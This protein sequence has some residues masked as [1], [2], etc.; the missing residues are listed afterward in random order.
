MV[1][2][3]NILSEKQACF[4]QLLL[5][6]VK[7]RIGFGVILLAI[8]FN[9]CSVN[10]YLD[11]E[12]Y[13]LQSNKLKF[14][15]KAKVK[16]KPSLQ[17]ELSLKYKQKPNS[18]FLFL[19]PREWVYYK[20][21]PK[22][23]SSRFNKWLLT[24]IAE[25]PTIY[26]GEKSQQTVQSIEET[27][28]KKGYYDAEVFYD[29]EIKGKKANVTYYVNPG[30]LYTV[31]KITYESD[32]KEIRSILNNEK[33]D[34]YFKNGSAL[35]DENYAKERDRIVKALQNNGYA[36]FLRD[37]VS[38]AEADTT[39]D[40]K[41]ADVFIKILPPYSDSIH[42][43]YSVG[44]ITIYPNFSPLIPKE[45]LKEQIIEEHKFIDTTFN[46]WVKPS[47][48]INAIAL[49]KGDLYSI[50]ND[51]KTNRR[52]S[53]LGV[54]KFI[55][56]RPEVAP[57]DSTVLNFRIELTPNKKLEIGLDF[58]LNYSN[59]NS[60]GRPG[61]LFG[62]TGSP[63]FRN[64]N[65]FKGA[66]ALVTNLTGGMEFNP[67][68]R[69]VNFWNTL[70]L[71]VQTELFLP[72]FNDFLG[73]WKRLDKIRL[74]R[75]VRNVDDRFYTL[76]RENAQ[77]RFSASYNYVWVLDFYQY[78]L[79]NASF[80]YNLQKSNT[81][82]YIINHIG[83]DYL[84]PIAEPA[85]EEIFEDNPFFERSF[86]QQLFTSF[87]FR[88]FNYI[89]N[90]RKVR[91]KSNYVG[92]NVETAGAEIWGINQLTN[93]INGQKDTFQL[94]N[95]DFSQYLKLSA[96]FRFF[97]E[98]T[99]KQSFASRIFI[100]MARP[101]GNSSDVP[102]VKQFS[103]G[104]PGSIRA[105]VQRGLGPGG[106]LDT[107][108]HNVDNRYRLNRENRL[109]LYQQG[110]LRLELN[111]EYRFNLYWRLDG[112]IFLD[113]GNVWTI[114]ADSTRC[115]SQ[116]RFNSK[117]N[118]GCATSGIVNDP[119]YKQIA[120]GTGMGFRFDFTY[121]I[122]RLDLGTRLRYPFPLIRNGDARELDYWN[123]F[124]GWGIKDINFNLGFG[125]PF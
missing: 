89:Y 86:G 36:Y 99:P 66:E 50:S 121:F 77:T 105:W 54:F 16:N 61:N 124:E 113:A 108:A 41:G 1:I 123:S 115:G 26:D 88:D 65:I 78:N 110:D 12:E 29:D 100:G 15:K 47:V 30:K 28:K 72:K 33:P 43:Q 39:T 76:L 48:I 3:N 116:F 2:V 51:E 25:T 58:E 38:H 7:Q 4:L 18:N 32:D 6:L 20:S 57:N 119:F 49:K 102:Y 94:G 35:N 81:H 23:D 112:A 82:R 83:I 93:A 10:K 60:V 13:L 85:L 74:G 80:G 106:Y 79:I 19:V 64:R 125:Y 56:I 37:Y 71:G 91:G 52:L 27:L 21:H 62:I 84:S 107:L 8:L 31:K 118:E 45:L 55:R 95:V 111:L 11:S 122:I 101:F 104:G 44:E 97:K 22:Q 96:D 75:K 90:S 73:I 14:D 70:D 103:V 69:G 120:I 40:G 117:L 98:I 24:R 87:L 17:Y 9:S 109:K 42:T 34:T 68:F 46:F 114:N 67:D 53:N 5:R 92:L 59:N 63:S